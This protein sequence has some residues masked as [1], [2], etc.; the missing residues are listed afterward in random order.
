MA[1]EEKSG[2]SQGFVIARRFANEAQA[3]VYQAKLRNA[4]ISCF[5]SNTH[6]GAILHLPNQRF[7]LHVMR[8]DMEEALKVMNELDINARTRV[9]TDY[10]DADLGDIAYEKAIHDYESRLMEAR[11]RQVLIAG[12]ILLL[13]IIIYALIVWYTGVPR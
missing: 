5:L 6:T 13:I 11:G 1:T 4:G 2:K 12:G 7:L 9:E 10:R 8:E 3:A